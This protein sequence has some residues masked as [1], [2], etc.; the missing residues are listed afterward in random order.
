VISGNGSYGVS[1]NAGGTGDVIAGNWIGLDATGLKAAGNSVSGVLINS[2]AFNLIGGA[3]AAWAN[4]I[5]GNG[6]AEVQ[7]EFANSVGNV[8]QG[9]DLG[10]DATLF[11]VAS[12]APYGILVFNAPGNEIGGATPGTGNLIV[13][14][15]I[16]GIDI[17]D[18]NSF[19]NVVIGNLIG[20]GEVVNSPAANGV[21]ILINNASDNTVGGTAAGF[22]NVIRGNGYNPVLVA[23]VGAKNNN[24]GGNVIG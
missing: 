13:G 9:N 20:P 21:G 23:G 6:S 16:A 12:P 8:V 24:T 17:S 11:N 15:K 3:S 19:F 10:T 4:V 18:P 2:A 1:L 5:S 7:I 22:A 14:H